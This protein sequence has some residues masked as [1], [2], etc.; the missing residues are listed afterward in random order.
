[1]RLLTEVSSM[2]GVLM[3]GIVIGSF[4]ADSAALW[5]LVLALAVVV[6]VI[7]GVALVQRSRKP[8][9]TA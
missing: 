1:M 8:A 3:V 5:P 4:L 9:P 2:I 7:Q 6:L